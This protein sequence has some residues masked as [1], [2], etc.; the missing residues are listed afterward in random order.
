MGE[1]MMTMKKI[2]AVD[3]DGTVVRHEYPEVGEDVPDAVRVL[4]RISESGVHLILW[5][6]RDALHLSDAMAWFTER[7]IKLWRTNYNPEQ[8]KW[9]SSPKA[10]AQVYI[11]D[12]ALGVP[13]VYPVD[14][15]RPYVDWRAVEK[16]LEDRGWLGSVRSVTPI[17]DD[18]SDTQI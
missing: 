9:T 13:L 11:D 10:Y 15:G 5:T 8:Y 16:Q 4:K 1:G 6:M 17:C 2:I 18:Q 14:G 12:A 3:F 7:G